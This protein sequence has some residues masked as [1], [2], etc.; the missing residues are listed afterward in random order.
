[1]TIHKKYNEIVL[2]NSVNNFCFDIYVCFEICLNISSS[3][4]FFKK[5]NHQNNCSIICCIFLY[6]KNKYSGISKR[7][8]I[9]N[10]VI[11]FK[12][13]LTFIILA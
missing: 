3:L 6:L 12:I 1:M 7:N 8:F 4:D 2:N 13:K 5:L 10:T 9:I 11:N